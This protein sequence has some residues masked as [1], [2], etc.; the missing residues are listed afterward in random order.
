MCWLMLSG[1]VRFE[2]SDKHPRLNWRSAM[3]Y[4]A[5]LGLAMAYIAVLGGAQ[6]YVH[7]EPMAR[8]TFKVERSGAQGDLERSPLNVPVAGAGQNVQP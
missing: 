4:I 5:V 3:A 8:G 1:M 6:A 7:V 2:L